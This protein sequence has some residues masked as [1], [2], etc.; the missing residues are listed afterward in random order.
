MNN[1]DVF[2][3]S[4]ATVASVYSLAVARE[5]AM[6]DVF[7]SR[8]RSYHPE[9]P[10]EERWE[11]AVTATIFATLVLCPPGLWLARMTGE[12]EPGRQALSCFMHSPTRSGRK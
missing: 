5:F 10:V 4:A 12:R 9:E 11:Y 7:G 6:E 8:M 1:R 3:L 2:P